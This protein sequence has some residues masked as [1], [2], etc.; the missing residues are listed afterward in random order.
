VTRAAVGLVGT[1][2]MG[3]AIGAALRDGGARVVATVRGRSTRSALLAE[4][5]GIEL[6]ADL[7]A[8][9]AAAGV[10]L[11]V[12][13]PG[14]AIA[15][16]TDVAE[17]CRR[18]GARPLAAD[19]NAVSPATLARIAA[20]LADAGVDLVDGSISG[21]PPR[22]DGTTRLYLAG[23]RA[24]EVAA[25]PLARLDVRVLGDRLGAASALKMCTASVY[26]GTTALVL[27]ALLA[28]RAN[29]V[30]EAVLA[31]LEAGAPELVADL[32]PSLASAAA[33]AGRFADEMREIAGAQDAAGLGD[34]LFLAVEATYAAFATSALAAGAPEPVAPPAALAALLDAAAPNR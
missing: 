29:G 12:T 15:A 14:S 23:P 31:D 24:G 19:L 4:A 3:S 26:K 17:A 9:V 2:A 21:P 8:V 18:S 11:C 13:P 34:E 25:L 1:G 30:A 32:G 10:V 7:D 33:K 20:I 16:A 28:A 22:R 6:L 27:R 5:A